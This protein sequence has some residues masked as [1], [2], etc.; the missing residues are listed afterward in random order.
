MKSVTSKYD[1][2]GQNVT[3]E[4]FVAK[5]RKYFKLGKLRRTVFDRPRANGCRLFLTNSRV[6]GELQS[7]AIFVPNGVDEREWRQMLADEF[8]IRV[9]EFGPAPI[10]AGES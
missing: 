8:R 5:Y 10:A 6:L 1:E 4:E 9:R 2:D 7:A 3:P